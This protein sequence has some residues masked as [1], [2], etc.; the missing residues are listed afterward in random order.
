MY[1]GGWKTC[2]IDASSASTASYEEGETIASRSVVDRSRRA[3]RILALQSDMSVAGRRGARGYVDTIV[4]GAK[5][6]PTQMSGEITEGARM[7]TVI[8]ISATSSSS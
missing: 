7:R 2:A 3:C 5:K 8:R 4:R 6:Q 1:R